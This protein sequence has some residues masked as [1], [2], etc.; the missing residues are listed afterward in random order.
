MIPRIEGPLGEKIERLFDITFNDKSKVP[1]LAEAYAGVIDAIP[2]M[3]GTDFAARLR[4]AKYDGD[5]LE[6]I[7]KE[8]ADYMNALSDS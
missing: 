4:E 3:A 2:Q 8:A 6:Q 5:R 1:D 7:A